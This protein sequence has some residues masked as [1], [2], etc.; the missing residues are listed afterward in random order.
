[1]PTPRTEQ[2]LARLADLSPRKI[3]A[4]LDR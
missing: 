1:M 4:E 2:A 3:V